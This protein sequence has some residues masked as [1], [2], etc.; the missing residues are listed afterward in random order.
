MLG[1]E[2]VIRRAVPSNEYSYQYRSSP[3]SEASFTTR[4]TRAIPHAV[5]T[6]LGLVEARA[7]SRPLN[8]A[9]GLQ[10]SLVDYPSSAV[11]EVLVNAL[12]HRTLP[13]EGIVDI[14]HTPDRLVIQSPGGLVAGVTPEN[15]LTHPSTPRHRL[16]GEAVALLRL[17]ERTG[18]GIDRAY[19]EMLRVGKEPPAIEDD[20][21][22]VRATLRGGVGN[23][24]FVR[25][26]RDL[27]EPVSGDVEILITLAVLRTSAVVDAPTLAQ[28]IQRTA[29]EAQDVL[30]RMSDDELGLL[31]PTRRTLRRPFPAYR[32]RNGPLAALA[33]AVT[34]RRR[35]IDET[36]QKVIEHVQEYGFVTNR[37]LQRL[38]D[39]DLFAARN[40]LSDLRERGLLEKLGAARAVRESRTDRDPSSPSTSA[41]L[42]YRERATR[43]QLRISCASM[44]S[45]SP[46]SRKLSHE[47]LWV[48]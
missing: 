23:D 28:A 9:G 39:R 44:T 22:R 12:V 43:R 18:Q 19:R 41:Q 10:L 13:A 24:A 20:G 25:F 42:M 31:E 32:L 27:P 40:M 11:R 47:R 30:A 26:V 1:S 15:I 34:Y 2:D 37:T 3:G 17:A 6:I 45:S 36:D 46:R 38:F 14:E 21:L 8:L 5:E 48:G 16:L 33:R 7:E 35:T 4:G 29:P